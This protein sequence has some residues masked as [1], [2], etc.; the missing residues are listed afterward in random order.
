MKKEYIK[1]DGTVF[2]IALMAWIIKDENGEPTGMWGI[3]RDIA[4]N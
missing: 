3:V 4:K 2:P 1:K